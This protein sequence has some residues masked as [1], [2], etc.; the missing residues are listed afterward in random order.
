MYYAQREA[1]ELGT[2][3][4]NTFDVLNSL[5]FGRSDAGSNGLL[6]PLA[7]LVDGTEADDAVDEE[8]EGEALALAAQGAVLSADVLSMLEHAG[9]DHL[10]C[11]ARLLF[12]RIVNELSHD[13]AALASV[14][15]GA[16]AFVH[17][18]KR[19]AEA[20]GLPRPVGPKG[21]TLSP[22]AAAHW[23]LVLEEMGKKKEPE[24][25]GMG[26][27]GM[28]FGREGEGEQE[29]WLLTEPERGGRSGCGPARPA[30]ARL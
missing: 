9:T 6:F 12:A 7:R 20:L 26:M 14:Q 18:V 8:G 1:T 29:P 27:F 24:A 21:A 30:L 3:G 15:T 25:G 5:G 11:E 23:D 17:E 16:R 22:V 10:G 28:M 19:S 13:D 2:G 4:F